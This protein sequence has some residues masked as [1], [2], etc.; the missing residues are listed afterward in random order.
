MTSAA[1]SC[2]HHIVTCL[3]S[4]GFGLVTLAQRYVVKMEDRFLQYCYHGE[5][6]NLQELFRSKAVD[7]DVQDEDGC[8]GLHL[9]IG[10][11]YRDIVKLLLRHKPD[12]GIKNNEG[13]SC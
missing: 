4:R 3:E 8:T 7:V 13:H 1:R 2:G 11:R 10:E 5:L 6:E 9:A 12:F